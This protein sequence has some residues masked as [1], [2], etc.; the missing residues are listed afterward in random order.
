M[1]LATST[2]VSIGEAATGSVRYEIIQETNRS[3]QK[4]ITA[5]YGILY[6]SLQAVVCSA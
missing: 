5:A 3:F 1:S 2:W 6:R 4:Q